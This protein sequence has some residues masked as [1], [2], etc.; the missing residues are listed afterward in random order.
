MAGATFG[1]R[2]KLMADGK[3][4][5]WYTTLDFDGWKTER[6]A[7]YKEADARALG[8]KLC[9]EYNQNRAGVVTLS[10][11][12]LEKA[13]EAFC[14]RKVD[15]ANK[16]IKDN[17]HDN[18][19]YQ[20]THFFKSNKVEGIS[21]ITKTLIVEWALSMKGENYNYNTVNISLK[22]VRAFLNFCVV[23]GWLKVS[24]FPANIMTP[25]KSEGHYFTKEERALLLAPTISTS[26]KEKTADLLLIDATR[27]GQHQGL[28]LSQIWGIK[29]EDYLEAENRLST[30]GIKRKLDKNVICH[31]VTL[32]SIKHAAQLNK[33][34]HG[35]RVFKNW[36]SP[37]IMSKAFLRKRKA[38]GIAKGRFH[39]LKHTAVSELMSQGFSDVEVGEITNTSPKTISTVYTHADQEELKTKFQK[40]EF[41]QL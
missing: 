37:G 22:S 4:T 31:P 35:E 3:T 30:E 19:R 17:T 33:C 39:D 26:E 41:R 9:G 29:I 28:R 40:F 7:G 32:E 38:V 8:I 13:L 34:G 12:P 20:L 15:K 10:R 24:P 21:D 36:S 16:P 11:M 18:N 23:K 6:Y 5:K 2:D 14:S 27:I 25:Y 1:T